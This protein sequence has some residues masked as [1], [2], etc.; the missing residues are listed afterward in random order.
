PAFP[1]L[2]AFSGQEPALEMPGHVV[3]VNTLNHHPLLG[4]LSL[5]NC[6]RVVFPL[7]FGGPDEVDDWTLAAWCDHCHPKAGLVIGAKTGYESSD[8]RFGEPLAD[9]IL[10]KV[11]AFEIAYYED[12]PFDVLPI[13]Y[14][15]LNCGFRVPLVGASGKDSNAHALGTMRTYARLERGS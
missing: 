8:F 15:L 14:D 2:L 13:W 12:S 6:H 11:D 5:L 1:N 10:G 3:A 4:S 9:L 7:R